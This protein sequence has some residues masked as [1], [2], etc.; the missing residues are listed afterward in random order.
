LAVRGGYG[1]DHVDVRELQ[2]GIAERRDRAV[3]LLGQAVRSLEEELSASDML[4]QPQAAVA[5]APKP[6]NSIFLVHGHD[7]AALHEVARFV[8]QIDLEPI[9]LREQPDMGRTIIEKFEHFAGQV[10]FA[11]VL[12]TPDDIAGTQGMPDSALRARQNVIFE[13]GYFVGKLGRGRACLLRKGN[14]E[15]PS[16]LAGVIYKELDAGGGWKI[17]LGMELKAANLDF[18]ANKMWG[19]HNAQ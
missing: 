12:L 7:E 16:D 13:L 3:A 6:K 11:I 5:P 1:E 17:Q 2:H 14:V 10:G 8:K 18:D 19:S 9:I 4:V 15:I